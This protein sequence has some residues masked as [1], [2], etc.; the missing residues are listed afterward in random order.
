MSQ[1][2][3]AARR[4]VAVRRRVALSTSSTAVVG[5]VIAA[6]STC[7]TSPVP[8][9]SSRMIPAEIVRATCGAM[10]SSCSISRRRSSISFA[11]FGRSSGDF[12]VAHSTSS[13][14]C[15][16]TPGFFTLGRGT[17]SVACWKAIC[18][19]CSPL[20]GCSP[21]SISYSMMPSE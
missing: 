16:G 15:S 12:S 17:E 11:S 3:L 1:P 13:S 7:V 20:Y 4:F 5:A 19:G 9:L 14:S 10:P 6:G 8:L 18:I 2:P 21:T